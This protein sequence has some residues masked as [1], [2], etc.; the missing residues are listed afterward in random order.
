MLNKIYFALS[1]IT[2]PVFASAEQLGQT[3]TFLENA[4]KIVTDILVPLAFT[5]ALLY[6]FYGV[7]KY[8]WSEGTEKAA[9]KNIMIWGVVALFV[10]SSIWG[11]IYFIQGEIGINSTETNPKIPSVIK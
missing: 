4:L 5:L 1:L 6:F 7:A 9:G 2:L 11:I 3:R 8:I 10:M